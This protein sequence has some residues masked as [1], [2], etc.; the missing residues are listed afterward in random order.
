MG[1]VR[2]RVVIVH[3]YDKDKITKIRE[4]AVQ[5]FQKVVL[6]DYAHSNYDVDSK[7][8]SPIMESYINNEYSFMIMGECSKIGWSTADLFEE[9]R[10]EWI[11]QVQS[12]GDC[13]KILLIDFG[14]DYEH[15]SEEYESIE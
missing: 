9:K 11:K 6:E 5:Y 8:V 13:Y 14:E 15:Q 2:N 12:S 7:M 4:S 3:H 10:K 1:I